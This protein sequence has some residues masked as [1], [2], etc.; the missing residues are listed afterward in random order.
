M[1]SVQVRVTQL[2][3]IVVEVAVVVIVIAAAIVVA[4]AVVLLR[5]RIRVGRLRCRRYIGRVAQGRADITDTLQTI[6]TNALNGRKNH[7]VG[8]SVGT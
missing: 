5:S 6:R 7:K 1:V 3:V 4:V 2:I 8:S